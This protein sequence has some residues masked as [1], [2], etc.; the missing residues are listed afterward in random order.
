M[1]DRIGQFFLGLAIA[2][3]DLKGL[4][5][6][7]QYLAAM[8]RPTTTD[9]SPYFGQWHGTN[10]QIQR[11]IIGVLH[12]I[13]NVIGATEYRS[14]RDGAAVAD[15]VSRVSPE[16]RAAW[17]EIVAVATN[18]RGRRMSALLMRIRNGAAFHYGFRGNGLAAAYGRRFAP[19]APPPNQAAQFSTGT[20][21]NATRFYYADAAAQQVMVENLDGENA[22]IDEL[23]ELANTV[24]VAVASVLVVFI[25]SRNPSGA[26]E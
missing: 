23:L 24:N 12:E 13:M 3:N 15:L 20:D 6:F 9:Y 25:R 11:W 21:M 5:M 14:V 4:V 26:D 7:E 2:F 22:M 8:G 17:N 1:N 18:T 10:V 19:G 16:N